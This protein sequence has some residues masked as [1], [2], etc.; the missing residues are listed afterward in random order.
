[1]PSGK[2]HSRAERRT[3]KRLEATGG[4]APDFWTAEEKAAFAELTPRAKEVVLRK[5]AE[6]TAAVNEKMREAAQARQAVPEALPD[7]LAHLKRS[8]EKVRERKAD[9]FLRHMGHEPS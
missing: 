5:E 3:R 2:S 6:R 1:M 4:D 9:A 7:F 8:N